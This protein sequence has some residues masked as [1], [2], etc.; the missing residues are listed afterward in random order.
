M[1]M[2]LTL[3]GGERFPDGVV[4]STDRGTVD[5]HRPNFESYLIIAPQ[6]EIAKYRV[7]FLLTLVVRMISID[8]VE[9]PPGVVGHE[10]AQG[11]VVKELVVECDGHDFHDR[12]K[13]QASRDRAR[14][15]ELQLRDLAVVRFTGSDIFR[16]PFR[17]ADQALD[18]LQAQVDRVGRAPS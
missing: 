9:Y 1:F 17:C 2:A 16:D 15:R 11:R 10:D 8:Y 3:I 5:F 7:D 4:F 6:A 12:T 18:V 13:Q 14:D